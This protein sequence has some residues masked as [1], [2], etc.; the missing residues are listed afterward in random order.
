M[1]SQDRAVPADWQ[2]ACPQ[3]RPGDLEIAADLAICRQCATVYNRLSGI[4]H[5]LPDERA[6]HF[7]DFLGRY[8]RI[9]HAEGR[10]SDDSQFYRAL[11]NCPSAHPLA[12]Q[13][14]IRRRSF[15]MLST[16]LEKT[17]NRGARII[18]AG[19]GVGWLS[20][21]LAQA[22]FRPCAV[23]LSVDETDGLAAAKHLDCH[24][25]LIRAEFDHLPF[26][27]DQAD[28]LIF[29]A[30]FHY[31]TEFSKTLKEA[32]RVVVPG[33]SIIIL[34]TP[35]YRDECSGRQM[36]EEQRV[37]FERRFGDCSDA[38]PHEGFLTWDTID[39]LGDKL[40]L[41]WTISRPWYGLKWALRPL[42]ARIRGSREPATFAILCAVTRQCG[43]EYSEIS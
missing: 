14:T 37:D 18:D 41:E 17:Q 27:D 42:L 3:C 22:G 40:G 31:S 23:D 35:V 6:E 33:G 8:T 28:V 20:N 30:S 10:S 26:A 38:L 7:R 34:D 24:W 5:F 1:S 43:E 2:L 13:W 32:C 15:E 12:W 25:P 11:P 19:T 29:N 21:R 39:R 4:W 16:M 36:L 9:R